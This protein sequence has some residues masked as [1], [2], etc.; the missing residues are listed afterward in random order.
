MK[1]KIDRQNSLRISAQK[2]SKGFTLIELM[3][4]VA[5]IGILTAVALPAYTNYT[6]RA[7]VSECLSVADGFKKRATI[8]FTSRGTWPADLTTLLSDPA[9]TTSFNAGTYISGVDYAAAA[10]FS[11]S[12]IECT[13][14]N[15]AHAAIAGQTL[16]IRSATNPLGA[17]AQSNVVWLCGLAAA[18]AGWIDTAN[19]VFNTTVGNAYLPASCKP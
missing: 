9:A 4:V 16:S 12:A 11:Q 5:I 15:K 10:D 18:N 8:N 7:Q 14:G 3:I 6:I 2:R 17:T 19:D 13:F 1:N